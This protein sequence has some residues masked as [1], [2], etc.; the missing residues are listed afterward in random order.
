[1]NSFFKHKDNHKLMWLARNY[2]AIIDYFITNEK[3]AKLISDVRVYR[4]A[5]LETDH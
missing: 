4:C 1:M 3:M 2:K 5:E